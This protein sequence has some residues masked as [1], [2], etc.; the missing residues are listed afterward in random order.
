[1]AHSANES[2]PLDE[3]VHAAEVLTLLIAQKLAE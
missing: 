3:L 1:V 2:V